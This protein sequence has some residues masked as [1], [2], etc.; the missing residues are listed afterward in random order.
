VAFAAQIAAIDITPTMK[1]MEMHHC[2][3]CLLSAAS[4]IQTA[5]CWAANISLQHMLPRAFCTL[6]C[7]PAQEVAGMLHKG[8][9]AKLYPVVGGFA[10]YC[11]ETGLN[12]DTTLPVLLDVGTDDAE[13]HSM[14]SYPGAKHPRLSGA[15]L[16]EV[17][18]IMSC[19]PPYTA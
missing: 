18:I 15:A 4:A 17:C 5:G 10:Q 14:K 3:M 9:F 2:T 7:K 16:Q 1:H 19:P 6:S 8:K 12:P 13:R 11:A